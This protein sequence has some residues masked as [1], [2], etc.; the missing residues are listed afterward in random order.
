MHPA[1][2]MLLWGWLQATGPL[3]SSASC[4]HLAWLTWVVI[5]S[6]P[7]FR[8]SWHRPTCNGVASVPTGAVMREAPGQGAVLFCFQILE[9]GNRPGDRRVRAGQDQGLR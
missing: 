1:L 3:G 9:V 8:C 4:S 2:G 5:S 6:Q 7:C